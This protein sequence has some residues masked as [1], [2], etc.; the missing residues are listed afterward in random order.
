MDNSIHLPSKFSVRIQQFGVRVLGGN[1]MYKK[2]SNK[3]MS[4]ARLNHGKQQTT[5]LASLFSMIK[6]FDDQPR[7]LTHRE[8]LEKAIRYTADMGTINRYR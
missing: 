3:N 8:G 6:G 5:K 2:V 7:S 1:N 4:H